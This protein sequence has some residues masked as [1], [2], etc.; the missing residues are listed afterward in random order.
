MGQCWEL[1]VSAP[2]KAVLMSLADQANDHGVCW[3]SIRCIV[4]RTCLSRRTIIRA[5]ADLEALGYLSCRHDQ[6]RVTK[7]TIHPQPT[8]QAPRVADRCQS[9]TSARLTQVSA[10]H[11]GCA[12][13]AR[14]RCQSGT[15]TQKNRHESKT[16]T[17]R[18]EHGL[19]FP[20]GL[21][22]E[23]VVDVHGFVQDLPTPLAQQL[24]DEVAG[25]MAKP[26]RI[27]ASPVGFLRGLVQ[28]AQKGAFHPS[29]GIQVAEVRERT[30][31][32]EEA[33]AV[34]RTARLRRQE[35]SHS[36]G[37]RR[38]MRACLAEVGIALG[39]NERKGTSP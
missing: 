28:R 36:D 12:S 18:A 2:Q 32:E 4:T 27:K 1:Q 34:E 22:D 3:P 25:A 30:A 17:G 9:G 20:P 8:V 11:T 39:A 7:Y 26:G 31:A 6:G 21:A 13:V 16:T 24:L 23:V 37:A 10:M 35:A 15:Q 38:A 33:R 14:E 5:I 29:L 19:I